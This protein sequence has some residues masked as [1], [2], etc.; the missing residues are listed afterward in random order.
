E[1]SLICPGCG[2]ALTVSPSAVQCTGCRTRYAVEGDLPLLFVPNDWDAS[3][4]DITAEMKQFYEATP[5]PNYDDFDDVA[6]FIE[7][8][9]RGTFARLLNEQ[10]PFGSRVL[11]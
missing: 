10:I 5:F 7:K 11:E 1:L 2:A 3:R 4:R 6:T 8:A 9:R